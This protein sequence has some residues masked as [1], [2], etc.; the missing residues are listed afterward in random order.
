MPQESASVP[1]VFDHAKELFFTSNRFLAKAVAFAGIPFSVYREYDKAYLDK[2]KVSTVK[3]AENRKLP[4]RENWIFERT[5]SLAIIVAAFDSENDSIDALVAE[6]KEIPFCEDAKAE[7][8]CREFV[9]AMRGNKLIDRALFSTTPFLRF[10]DDED[11]TP[12]IRDTPKGK[13]AVWPGSKIIPL[14]ASEAV[15]AHLNL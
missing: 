10:W 11:G 4:G 14:N 3:E 9:R 12:R 5:P 8:K 7:T 2:H 15:K 6:A 1:P 13:V